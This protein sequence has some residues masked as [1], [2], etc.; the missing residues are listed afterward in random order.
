MSDVP[1]PL[2]FAPVRVRDDWAS[3]EACEAGAH[4]AL[5]KLPV[6]QRMPALFL[7]HG[8]PMNALADNPFT[9]SL[10]RL[11][12]DIPRPAA[13]LVVSAHWLTTRE[14]RVLCAGR[15]RMIHDFWGF[16]DE[17]YAIEYP[18]PGAP[19]VA[20]AVSALTG[21]VEDGE[22]GLDH[23]SWTLLRH[24]YPSADVPVL[25][26]SVDMAATPLAHVA[27]GAKLAPLRER[28][29]LILGSGNIVHNLGRIDWRRET[30]GYPWAVEFDEWASS[31]IAAGD[32]TALA[33]YAA[34]GPIAKQAVP[35]EDHY[36]P[37]LYA[38]A[39][40]ADDEPVTFTYEG[41]ELGS[42]SMRC[43]RVG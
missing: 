25:E 19:V 23:A 12:S 30:G 40:R 15:P 38:M 24:M 29:V 18:A 28:G 4:D 14:T 21:A 3:Q 34:V 2:N 27:L 10:A 26:L 5:A 39:V 8:S 13:V 22:W 1:E 41:M 9:R 11:A 17:L 31:R 35:T 32:T 43:V 7:G 36:L 16:P 37:L 33:H 6:T 20:D 42:I